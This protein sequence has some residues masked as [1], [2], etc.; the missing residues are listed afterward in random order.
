MYNL[1]HS[2]VGVPCQILLDPNSVFVDV[3]LGRSL[4]ENGCSEFFDKTGEVTNEG[5]TS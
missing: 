2:L 1:K 5:L 4:E 3:L